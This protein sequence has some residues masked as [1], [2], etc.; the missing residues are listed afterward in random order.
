MA[1]R[2]DKA[3]HNGFNRLQRCCER[4]AN[5]ID[6]FFD[7]ADAIITIRSLIRQAWTAYRWDGQAAR[8]ITPDGIWLTIMFA[9]DHQRAA[10]EI[11]RVTR[12]GGTVGLASWTPDGFIGEMFG[13]ITRHVP[14]PPGVASPV[15]WGTEHH[16]SGLFGPAI[17]DVRS[18]ERT[19][20]WRLPQP[21][22]SS[23]SSA[24]GTG[25]PSKPSRQPAT[26]A[27]TR[28]PPTWPTWPGAGTA[29][30]TAGASPSRPA[31]SRPS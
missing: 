12:P 4:R 20:T 19:C 6:A 16:L 1:C 11:I 10:D 17:A 24:A 28:W 29:T 3:W 26:T 23:P 21:R 25:R 8:A 27:A 5:V 2:A 15:L 9:P 18:V 7:L 13:V 30:T 31:T 14:G 22:S